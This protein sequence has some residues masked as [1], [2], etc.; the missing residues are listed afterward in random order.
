MIYSFGKGSMRHYSTL[1]Y[2]LQWV[3]RETLALGLMDFSIICGHR[4]ER[5]QNVAY[6][7]EPQKSKVRWPNSKHNKIPSEAG[8]CVPYINGKSSWNKLHC[9]VLAGIMLATAK[10]LGINM[11]WGGNWDVDGEPITDQK[12]DDLV[13]FEEVT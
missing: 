2:N 13:H 11:R 12:F 1:S 6:R 4:G 3:F 7:A 8:D 5:D 9:C 10:K